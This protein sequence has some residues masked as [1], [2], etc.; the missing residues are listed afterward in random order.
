MADKKDSLLQQIADGVTSKMGGSGLRDVLTSRLLFD[1]DD[2]FHPKGE[3]KGSVEN[4]I[5]A[6]GLRYGTLI[7]NDI[8]YLEQYLRPESDVLPKTIPPPGRP[9]TLPYREPA[10]E[11]PIRVKESSKWKF[12]QPANGKPFADVD[13]ERDPEASYKVANTEGLG[14]F[15]YVNSQTGYP[16]F[17]DLRPTNASGTSWE[18]KNI[19]TSADDHI[20][21]VW[22]FN[23]PSGM[24]KDSVSGRAEDDENSSIL[25]ELVKM[26][27]RHAGSPYAVYGPEKKSK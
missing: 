5:K 15:G 13:F 20:F 16:S 19:P 17:Q 24:V 6:L 27:L 8:P 9:G 3:R 11:P 1:E 7:S 14:R 18:M 12:D 26:A 21:D 22:D 2:K 23:T 10:Y 4:L 25:S